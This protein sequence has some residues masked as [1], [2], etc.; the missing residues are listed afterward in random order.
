MK[1]KNAPTPF[2]F[3]SKANKNIIKTVTA[4]QNHNTD[5]N[6]ANAPKNCKIFSITFN[7]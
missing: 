2:S 4:S 3:L 5:P 1:L 7:I 6:N